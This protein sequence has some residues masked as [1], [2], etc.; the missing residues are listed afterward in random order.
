MMIVITGASGNIGSKIAAHLLLQGQKV[1][2]VARTAEKLKEFA[3]KGAEIAAISLD[4]AGSLIKAFSGADAVF[5]MIPPNY[6]APDFRA[7][8]N[9]IGASIAEAIEKS[10]VKFIVNLSSQG[11]HLP[12]GTGPIK[13]LHDQEVRL[14][15]LKGVNI[16]HMRPTYFMENLLANIDMIKN[17]GIMGSAIRGDLKFPMVATKDIAKFAAERLMKKDFTGT[18][19]RDLLGQRDISM[20]EAAGIIAKKVNKPGI[21]YVQFSY[22]DTEKALTGMGFSADVSRLFIEMSKA[23]NDQLI[24]D[25]PRTKEN[26]TETPFEEFAEIFIRILAA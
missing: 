23:L 9:A 13:G 25:I 20:N 2:C 26:T 22:E 3:G 11:A 16:L 5:A 15:K 12:D 10:G 24:M 21:K 4:D 7:Y 1:R 8:Q 6:T 14:N 18:S 19:V 17:M